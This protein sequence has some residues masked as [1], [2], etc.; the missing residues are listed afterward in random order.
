VVSYGITSR[1]ARRAVDLARKQGLKT[2]NLRLQTVWPFPEGKIAE[3]AGNVKAFVVPELNLGQMVREVERAANGK[4][5]TIL[6]PHAGGS[7]HQ[8]EVIL[9]AIVEAAK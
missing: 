8:P 2:G 1:V 9:D 4:A 6:V 5:R 7:V 3:L